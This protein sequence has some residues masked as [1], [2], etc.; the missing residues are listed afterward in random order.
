[1]PDANQSPD[2]IEKLARRSWWAAL[3]GAGGLLVFVFSLGFGGYYLDQF[4]GRIEV[5]RAEVDS[6]DAVIAS[7]WERIDQLREQEDS[8]QALNDS[9]EAGF[10]QLSPGQVQ[11]II[12]AAEEATQSAERRPTA[13]IQVGNEEQRDAARRMGALLKQERFGKFRVPGIETVEHLPKNEQI[14]V[15]NSEDMELARAVRDSLAANG[16]VFTI[17]DLS[18]RYD[19]KPGILE[20]W[21]SSSG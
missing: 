2:R 9:L 14:R 17:R 11:Q 21:F 19:V 15:F 8:L 4:S 3:V 18:A 10:E 16:F 12:A 20:F 5:L 1:M 6:L 13:W 7:K